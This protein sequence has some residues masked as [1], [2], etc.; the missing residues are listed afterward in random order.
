M[1]EYMRIEPWDVSKIIMTRWPCML[2]QER[3]RFLGPRFMLELSSSS[4]RACA[5]YKDPLDEESPPDLRAY[6]DFS[7]RG[8]ARIESRISSEDCMS[9]GYF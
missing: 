3:L 4:A 5:P 7:R 2:K 1:Y 9:A 8:R 6:R